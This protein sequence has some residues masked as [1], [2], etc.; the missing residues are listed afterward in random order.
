MR[1][2]FTGLGALA[3][4]TATAIPNQQAA[5]DSQSKQDFSNSGNGGF[6]AHAGIPGTPFDF[7]AGFGGGLNGAG[8]G[9]GGYGF[10]GGSGG[11]GGGSGTGT[12]GSQGGNTGSGGYGG[13]ADMTGSGMNGGSGSGNGGG[14]GDMTGAGSG[15]GMGGGPG[16]G[17]N[18]GGFP[19]GGGYSPGNTGFGGP[20]PGGLGGGP[21]GGMGGGPSGGMGGGPYSGGGDGSGNGGSGGGQGGN[22]GSGAGGG[23][24]QGSFGGE[25]G[26]NQRFRCQGIA[27]PRCCQVN[28]LGVLDATCTARKFTST[29]RSLILTD[30]MTL[31]AQTL[32]V[33]QQ[34]FRDECSKLGSSAQCCT[35][36]F[37][38]RQPLCHLN[39]ALTRAD[40]AN[41]PTP[42]FSAPTSRLGFVTPCEWP[43]LVLHQIQQMSPSSSLLG[44]V[45]LWRIL[46]CTY[47]PTNS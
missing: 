4:V 11:Y 26:N 1:Y 38:V 46:S 32:P 40:P 28:A 34:A 43:R 16:M 25:G 23:G 13:G 24:D 45:M 41:R 17:G 27:V 6:N 5:Q 9:N 19:G 12:Y 14:P 3:L 42:H 10:G 15:G 22:S 31:A 35:L 8:K 33:S 20:P 30:V 47:F 29:T 7:S 44:L 18:T 37:A 39:A 21:T 36:P 2:I